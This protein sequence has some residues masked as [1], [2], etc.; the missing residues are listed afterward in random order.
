[1][2]VKIEKVEVFC[3]QD[4]QADFVR[5]EGSYQNVLVV[6]HGDNG[7]YGIGESDSPPQVVRALIESPPYNH[8]SCGLA[9]V[10]EGETLDDPRRLWQKMYDRTGWHGRHGV[11]IHAISALDIALWDLFARTEQRPLHEY[12]GGMQHRQLP[13]YATIYPMDEEPEAF[14]RQIGAYLEQGFRRIKVCVEPWWSDREKTVHNLQ[15]L[16]NHLGD[17]VEL[18]LDVAMEFTRL[19]Q[20]QPFIDCLE[21]LNFKWIEAPFDPDNLEDHCQLRALTDIPVGVGDLGFT[22]CKEFR[23]YLDADAFDIAQPDITMFGGVSEV[24]RL[25]Q[26]LAPAGKRI[27]PHAYN[28]DITLAVNA[29]FLCARQQLEPLEYSTS[30][31]LLR[32]QLIRN[33]LRIDEKGMI[34]LLNSS[35]NPC[36]GL[37]LELNWDIIRECQIP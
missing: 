13:A 7:L 31:S 23:P 1:M 2:S 21:A 18:M 3:L 12:F 37:G 16:R 5:F 24:M 33:P 32:R 17:E 10:L 9:G 22:T 29:H 27:I 20:L 35:E 28:T 8:L 11:A 19:P 36:Y 4:P 25:Q 14:E 15:H 34:S 26:L 6:V 30:P